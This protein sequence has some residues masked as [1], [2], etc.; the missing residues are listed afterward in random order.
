MPSEELV[1]IFLQVG[2]GNI[3]LVRRN[4][5]CITEWILKSPSPPVFYLIKTVVEL[6]SY[7]ESGFYPRFSCS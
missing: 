7:G 6:K 2:H 1:K 3:F 5:P 4:D